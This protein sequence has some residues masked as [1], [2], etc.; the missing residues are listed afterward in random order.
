MKVVQEGGL[1]P[2]TRLLASEDVEILREGVAGLNNL[3]LAARTV[4]D[5]EMWRRPAITHSVRRHDHRRASV[6]LFSLWKWLKTGGHCQGGACSRRSRS[7]G[8]GMW[9]SRKP[10]VC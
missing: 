10:G 3:S 2:L 7:C 1:E 5:R 8:R 6:R 9:K 4:R